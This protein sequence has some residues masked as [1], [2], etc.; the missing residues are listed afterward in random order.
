MSSA[1]QAGQKRLSNLKT[2]LLNE[3]KQEI[4]E[5][6]SLFD[7]NNDGCLD[8]HELKVAFRALGFDLSKRQVL[9]IIHEYDTDDR[10]LITYENFFQAVGEMIVNRDPLEEIRRAFRLFDDDG[11]GKITLRNLRRVA[12]ELGENLTDDELRAMIDEFDLDEDGEINEQEFI[13]ICT[14]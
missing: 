7:M 8:Y 6:F 3:Q 4:R 5:A 11:T 13:N 10:N 9:D 2:E 14:E 1:A 12:K